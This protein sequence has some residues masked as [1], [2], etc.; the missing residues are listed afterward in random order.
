MP[1]TTDLDIPNGDLCL[2]AMLRMPD[3][4][5]STVAVICHPHPQRGGDMDN[6]VVMIAA[7]SA[8]DAGLGALTFNFRGVGRSTGV[9][10]NGVGERD[11]VLSALKHARKLKGVTRV[12]L[13]GYSFGAGVASTLVD[14]DIAACALIA[15]PTQRLGADTLIATTKTPLLLISG[16]GDHVSSVNALLNAKRD[17]VEVVTV[18]GADH[19]WWGHESQLHGALK[20]FFARQA[21]AT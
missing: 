6:N 1:V 2:E 4:G 16:D 15:C 5:T 20:E 10:D 8:L 13:A 21:A 11:D 12:I 14:E 3:A 18:A 19:F 9:H 17:G 7:R